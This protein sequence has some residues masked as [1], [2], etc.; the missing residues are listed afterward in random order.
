MSLL[1]VAT[2][3]HNN[4]IKGIKYC[5]HHHSFGIVHLFSIASAP[6]FVQHLHFQPCHWFL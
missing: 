4:Y 5:E 3:I 2:K 6:G 1:T